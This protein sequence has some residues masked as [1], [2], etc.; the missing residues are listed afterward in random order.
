MDSHANHGNAEHLVQFYESE[1][2]LIDGIADYI[3]SAIA[4][5]D[6][7]IVIATKPHLQALEENLRQRHLLNQTP[8]GAGTR[9]MPI[10]AHRML[11]LFMVDGMP[12]ETLFTSVIGGI[13][14]SAE[15]EHQRNICVFG[16]MVAI[17]CGE[18]YDNLRSDGKH[19]AAIRV[20]ECFNR[21]LAQHGFSLLCGYPMDAFP[22]E[23]D[24]VAFHQVC[25]LHSSVIPT[26]QYNSRANIDQLQRTIA[27]LQ[28][29]AFSLVSEVNERL[30]IEQALREVNFD[31][32]TG[33][34]NRSVFQDRLHMEIRRSHRD[35]I[36]LAVLFIDLDHFKEINDTLGHHSGDL[37][38][39]QVAQRL[40]AS[41]REN[42]TVARLGGD[43]FTIILSELEDPEMAGEVA[44][45]ILQNLIAPFPLGSD[46]VHVSASIGITLYPQDAANVAELLRNADQAMYASKDRGRNRVSYFTRSMQVAAQ[47]RRRL[48][49]ELRRAVADKQLRL[50][51][52][53]IVHLATGEICKAEAL[54]RWE[55][56]ARGMVS[57]AEFIPI[58]EHTG[59]IVDI[60]EWVFHEAARH[61]AR[62]R[63]LQPNFQISINVSP[64]QFQRKRET[65]FSW[66]RFLSEGKAWERQSPMGIAVEITEGLLL[67]ASN[68]V[69]NQLLA[70]RDAGIQVSLDDFGTGYSSL[71]YLRKFDIDYLKIDQSFVVDLDINSNNLALCEAIIVMAHKLGLKV[72]AEGVETEKQRSLLADAGCDFGQG[73]L[74][75]RAVAPNEFEALLLSPARS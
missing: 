27:S 49:S 50:F 57:P 18:Q 29:K 53:P 12:D 21:L 33:L 32:L 7:G 75:S 38:L 68:A 24:G 25:G 72:I 52:Q 23:E 28:Q 59:M 15:A 74:F 40:M 10:E 9:Y 66:A 19:A 14:L 73:Y 6:V 22:R 8:A 48:T 70:F 46:I 64:A 30:L 16:E 5:G 34:P 63:K 54:V 13:I 4:A 44:E 20:E 39:R 69:I 26:E 56:P 37:L 43:E 3:G 11:P 51:Y 35:N 47:R 45:Q 41:V 58:A 42:D 55:H 2:Y 31:K 61:A 71:S 17:L 67:D 62:W 65:E 36:S 60:G 1:A